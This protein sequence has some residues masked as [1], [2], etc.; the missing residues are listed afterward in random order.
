VKWP[1]YR[2]RGNSA[3][4]G[5]LSAT[6]RGSSRSLETRKGVW[7]GSEGGCE[8]IGTSTGWRNGATRSPRWRLADR[9]SRTHHRERGAAGPAGTPW[10]SSNATR[11]TCTGPGR[12]I[13][14]GNLHLHG[15][16]RRS[17]CPRTSILRRPPI[18]SVSPLTAAAPDSL[19]LRTR[20]LI[21]RVP[22]KA[23]LR[24]REPATGTERACETGRTGVAWRL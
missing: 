9:H 22:R 13:S 5:P 1:H 24:A 18:T 2:L 8:S 15:Q 6:L 23:G 7:R 11:S 16:L 21:S 12:K 17:S 20:G 3:P 10:G 14:P 19:R 4:V